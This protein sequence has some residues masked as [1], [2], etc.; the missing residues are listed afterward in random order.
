M[1][2]LQQLF[3][4]KKMVLIQFKTGDWVKRQ[5]TLT[6]SGWIVVLWPA[7][8]DGVHMLR[9]DGTAVGYFC[10]KWLPL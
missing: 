7:L 9:D 10:D 1:N 8:G 3:A 5:A 6:E 2:W 4:P